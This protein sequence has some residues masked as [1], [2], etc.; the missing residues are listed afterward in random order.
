MTMRPRL[1]IAI[2]LGGLL[3]TLAPVTASQAQTFAVVKNARNRVASV[4]KNELKAL[5]TGKTKAWSGAAVIVVVDRAG[6]APF[7]AFA[8]ATFGVSAKTLHSK[9]KQEVFK[10]EMAKPLQGSTDAEVIAQVASTA[11]AIGIVSAAAVSGLPSNVAIL[12][13]E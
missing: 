3:S 9:I 5:Y 11:G 4:S 1:V 13:I 10:G 8:E 6:F 7:T 2:T 12:A